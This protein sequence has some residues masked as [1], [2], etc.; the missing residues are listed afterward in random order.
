[1]KLDRRMFTVGTATT[2]GLWSLGDL[3]RGSS[4]DIGPQLG[5]G[6]SLAGPEFGT[7]DPQFS[8]ANPGTLGRDYTF[9]SRQ[10]VQY[11]F[12]HGVK[13]FRIPIS[14]ER[15]QPKLGGELDVVYFGGLQKLL[16]WITDVGGNA[17]LDLHNYGRYRRSIDGRPIEAVLGESKK[18]KVL[19]S[20]EDL[21]SVWRRIAQQLKGHYSIAA[22]GIMNEPH[23]LQGLDWATASNQVVAAIR[24][25]DQQRWISVSGIDWATSERFAEVNG[26]I[27]WINDPAQRTMYEAHAYFDS[28]ASGKYAESFAEEAK[29]DPHIA[30]R[31]SKTLEPFL[32]WCQRNHVYGFVGEIGVPNEPQWLELLAEACRLIHEA[33]ASVSYWAAGEWWGD[34]PLSVQPK[35]FDAPLPAQMKTVVSN[36][37]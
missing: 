28:D 36:M 37:G 35:N 13:S 1:M 18:G 24:E 21:A 12:D 34:Y 6:V 23:N 10:T 4:E 30:Q 9:N 17:I 20:V 32:N 2:L 5:V 8:Q 11:F 3:A 14:W 26:E 7:H 27:A 25:V 22:Y 29:R 16:S 19:L 33:N 15:L 31:P